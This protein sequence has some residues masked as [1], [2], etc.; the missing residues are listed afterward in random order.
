MDNQGQFLTVGREL[1][2]ADPALADMLDETADDAGAG[3]KAILMVLDAEGLFEGA[4]VEALDRYID[5]A[6]HPFRCLLAGAAVAKDA[7]P[8]LRRRHAQNEISG[9]G[10]DGAGEAPGTAA[11]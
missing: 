7:G 10:D 3:I 11:E 1:Y 9:A 2:D 6:E 5:L 4:S 8:L